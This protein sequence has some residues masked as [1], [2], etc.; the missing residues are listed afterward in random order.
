ME[1]AASRSDRLHRK[2][3]PHY[4]RDMK[5]TETSKP[6]SVIALLRNQ[7]QKGECTV[8]IINRFCIQ[9]KIDANTL[10][11]NLCLSNIY[12]LPP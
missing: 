11:I 9:V 1:G 10:L 5:I 3:T 4:K 12:S 7:S 8:N 6:D 2:D